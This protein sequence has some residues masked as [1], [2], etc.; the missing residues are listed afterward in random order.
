MQPKKTAIFIGNSGFPY[1]ISAFTEKTRLMGMIL[2]ESGHTVFVLSPFYKIKKNEKIENK[3][4]IDEINY[5]IFQK[6]QSNKFVA[7]GRYLWGL[8][9]QLFFVIKTS[10]NSTV[11]VFV[12]YCPFS[13]FFFYKVMFSIFRIEIILNIM[14]WHIAMYKNVNA[15]LFDLY[16]PKLVKKSVVISPFLYNKINN[17]NNK[18]KIF[19]L[20]AITDFDRIDK[21]IADQISK[22]KEE[23][24][25][26]YCGNIGYYEVIDIIIKSYELFYKYN[27]KSKLRL[28]LAGDSIKMRQLKE[29]CLEKKIMID[30]LNDLRFEELILTYYDS[31]ALLIPLRNTEQDKARFP[32]KIAEYTAVGRPI[33]TTWQGVIKDFFTNNENI[34]ASDHLTVEE[35]YNKM[36]FVSDH[37][38]LIERIGHEGKRVGIKEFDYKS[39]IT[40]FDVF[41]NN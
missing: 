28:I 1:K 4:K 10:R 17:Q 35:I 20:P 26:T 7:K 23:T 38:E 15:K 32:H 6:A 2:N 25:F 11:S 13:L 3:G 34:I 37:K 9:Q 29:L 41:I 31:T 21:I 18:C 27:P 36:K 33:I 19:L 40:S 12:S 5:V 8:L 24:I 39:Y 22:N 16:G 14:E 30:I